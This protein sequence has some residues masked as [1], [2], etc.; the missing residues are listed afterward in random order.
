[1]NA[2]LLSLIALLAAIILSMVS[3]VNVGLVALGLAWLIGV[4]FAG[5]SAEA[6]MA[7]FPVSLLLTITGVTLLFACAEENGT[8]KVLAAH[9][10]RLARGRR[11]AL[12]LLFFLIATLL[13][14]VGP[15]SIS[16]VA[17]IIPLAMAIGERA[18]LPWLLIAL[19][20]TNGANAGN[21]SPVSSVGVIANSR[22]AAIGLGGHE[23]RV[24]LANLLA[25]AFVSGVAFLLFGGLKLTG[26]AGEA[27]PVDRPRIE[28]S[29]WLTIGVIGLWIIGVVFFKLTLGLSTFIATA[30]LILLRATSEGAAIRLVPWNVVLMVTGVATLIALM[31]KTGGLDLFTTLLAQ[32]ATPGT[33]NGVMALIT[34][35]ISTYSSTSGVV[36]PA[37]LPTIPNLIQQIG[38]G[39]PLA[40][41]LSINVGSALVDVSPLSTLGAMCVAAVKNQDDSRRLFNQLFIWGLSMTIVGAIICQLGAGWFARIL[42]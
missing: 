23:W 7:G 3:R 11:W 32:L 1:M 37:F 21:L 41:A 34:A 17:L 13:S 16:S 2:A 22:M 40:L 20:V 27:A 36:L 31:E 6:V 33:V 39:D 25:H 10:I 35:I 14:M 30:L 42:S 38:G 24:F 26:E 4:Y 8:L 18:R 19:M 12:P 29:H 15:G 5:M 9:A 28:R